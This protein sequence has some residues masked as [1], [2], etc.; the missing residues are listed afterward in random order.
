MAHDAPSGALCI[1]CGSGLH[2]PSR[3]L[4]LSLVL[5]LLVAIPASAEIYRWVDAEG[6]PQYSDRPAP[7]AEVLREPPHSAA[8]QNAAASDPGQPLLGSYRA[9]EIVSPQSGETVRRDDGK[10]PIG[11]ILDPPLRDGHRLELVVDGAAVAVDQGSTQL[12]LTGLAF[13]SHT[14]VARI[15][16]AQGATDARTAPLGFHLRKPIPPGVLR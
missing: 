9:F 15:L 8:A 14:V 13:G 3:M 12:T 16:N 2:Y 4:R 6:Y 11:L 7:N 1:E 10:L 5:S